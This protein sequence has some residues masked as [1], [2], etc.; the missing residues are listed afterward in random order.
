MINGGGMKL[1]DI[2]VA[3]NGK[4]IEVCIESHIF[5]YESCEIAIFV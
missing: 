4:T 2:F 1:G 5:S 3:S